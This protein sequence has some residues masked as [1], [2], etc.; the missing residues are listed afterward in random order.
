MHINFH[1]TIPYLPFTIS[2]LYLQILLSPVFF[3]TNRF[4][5]CSFFHLF[6]YLQIKLEALDPGKKKIK[7]KIKNNKKSKISKN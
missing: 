3:S 2:S 5:P 7:I 4:L 6:L 1:S